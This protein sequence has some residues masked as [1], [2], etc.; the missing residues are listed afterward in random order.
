[1]SGWLGALASSAS[2]TSSSAPTSVPA[3]GPTSAPAAAVGGISPLIM[4]VA[5]I[6][7][8]VLV[9][10]T[11]Y[12]WARPDKLR[13]THAPCRP[14]RAHPLHLLGLYLI[15]ILAGPAMWWLLGPKAPPG[16]VKGPWSD[17]QVGSL[18]RFEHPGGAREKLAVIRADS[19]TV[20]IS[21][22]S[23]E[24][25]S[26]STESTL[27]RWYGEDDLRRMLDDWGAKDREENLRVA[28]MDV[29][30]QIYLK[31]MILGGK[32]V[33][34]RTWISTGVPG[35]I[36]RVDD[37][38]SGEM[39]TLLL[40]VDYVASPK[41]QVLSGLLAQFLWLPAV[42]LIARA[43]FPLGLERGLGLSLRHWVLDTMRAGVAYLAFFPVYLVLLWLASLVPGMPT[44]SLLTAIGAIGAGWK[45]LGVFSAVVLA[46]LV[47]E[48]FFRGLVQSMLRRYY[49]SPWV[50]VVVT[51]LF[52]AATHMSLHWMPALFVLGM[53]LGYN[54]ERTGRLL[55]PMLIHAAFNAVNLAS[56]LI[57]GF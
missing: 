23:G 56:W 42:L 35:W 9:A 34:T 32:K 19:N 27:P 25:G 28:G 43:T 49:G 1:L 14:N 21:T 38:K 24:T 51:S 29:S 45:V 4:V 54:Y 17:A 31:E 47:E 2:S 13:L 20:T 8:C 10:Y 50:A 37:D 5:S 40:L 55:A 53:V 6:G 18:A 15:L 16:M 44:H 26:N 46:P 52:F 39:T 12:R 33:Q 22:T 48:M 11:V 57:Y 7:I 3:S 41:R 36:V 30:C